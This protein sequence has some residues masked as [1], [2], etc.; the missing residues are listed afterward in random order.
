MSAAGCRRTSSSPTTGCRSS[1]DPP[2]PS[3]KRQ[4][5]APTRMLTIPDDLHQRLN[6]H[7]QEHVLAHWDRLDDTGRATL[8]RQVQGLDLDLL[9]RLY[10]RRGEKAVVPPPDRIA[11]VPVIPH[12]SPDYAE[13]RRQGE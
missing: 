10:E 8:L 3:R 7:H 9:T 1:S 5:A 6:R 13:K 4:K 2:P 11:P 12:D